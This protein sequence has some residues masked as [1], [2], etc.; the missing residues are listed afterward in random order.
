MSNLEGFVIKSL[1]LESFMRYLDK[2]RILFDEKFTV[3]TGRTGSGKTSLLDAITFALYGNTS[4]TDVK[5]IKVSDIVRKGGYTRL[6]FMQRGDEFEVERGLNSKGVPFLS[7]RKNGSSI[8]GGIAELNKVI[9]DIVG[10]DY[11]GFKNS[12]FV[13]QEEMRQ[14][15]SET[16][17]ERLEIFRKLFRLETFERAQEA[18]KGKLDG[19]RLEV[20]ECEASV[21]TRAEELQKL[22]SLKDELEMLREKERT[23][24]VSL[25]ALEDG[26]KEKEGRFEE[27]ERT[28]GDYLKLLAKMETL[29]NEVA[30]L[31]RDISERKSALEDYEETKTMMTELEKDVKNLEE[32]R[33]GFEALK[34]VSHEHS[35][36]EKELELRASGARELK[37]DHE[38]KLD[39]LGSRVEEEE[40]R[41][42]LLSTTISGEEA[43]SLLKQE[44]ALD[45]RL[46]RIEKELEWLSDK[47]S[48]IKTLKEERKKA[49]SLLEEVTERSS[50]INKDSFILTEIQSN[51]EKLRTDMES[52]NESYIS[53]SK[54]QQGDIDNLVERIEKLGFGDEERKRM[55]M[56]EETLSTLENDRIRLEKCRKKMNE[57]GDVSSVLKDLTARKDEK[58][59]E[60]ANLKKLEKKSQSSEKE[61]VILKDELKLLGKKKEEINEGL[62]RRR[63]QLEQVGKRITELEN[64]GKKLRKDEERL[65]HLR[66]KFSVYTILKDEV[67]HNRGIVMYAINQ[68]IPQLS[69]EASN[70]LADLSAGRF[71]KVRLEAMGEGAR[72]GIGILVEG[73]DGQWHDVF[74]FSGGE[75]TQINAALRFSIARELASLPQVGRTY[76]RMRTLFIDEGDLGSLDTESSRGLFV[77][78]LLD[79][80]VYFD[81]IILITHLSDVAEA[82]PGKVRVEMDQDKASRIFLDLGGN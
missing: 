69:I 6:R 73:L 8:M 4:R 11:V 21:R 30:S 72:Y 56:M 16:P 76:G 53:K 54:K 17:A 66:S 60:R 55:S 35:T 2:Q 32:L 57:M 65:E 75:R 80:G 3:I 79:M 63:G 24:E 78:K 39:T 22:P 74:E 29:E 7:L 26:L 50:S 38:K 5:S 62:N 82:F 48:V 28:H 68:I 19:L 81:K 41:I 71:A 44:G 43:F 46:R 14:I 77:K 64:M 49:S 18:V 42:S 25:K 40:E 37:N 20:R 58:E 70:D 12:T 59:A 67:F 15:G 36:L 27:M 52:E 23:D 9:V 10:L 13:R 1:E 45:E 61:Y 33:K 47:K 31:E 34:E 51:I